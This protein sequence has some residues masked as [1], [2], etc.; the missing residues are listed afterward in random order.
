MALEMFDK[1]RIK[2]F[3]KITG[4][5][6]LYYGGFYEGVRKNKYN[7][8]DVLS[9]L[10]DTFLSKLSDNVTTTDKLLIKYIVWIDNFYGWVCEGYGS[11]S[12]DVTAKIRTFKN[13]YLEY[14][15]KFELDSNNEIIGCIDSLVGEIEKL[16][17]KEDIEEVSKYVA[18]ITALE[19]KISSL[20]ADLSKA[21]TEIGNLRRRLAEEEK[22]GRKSV[23]TNTELRD[24]IQTRDKE[25]REQLALISELRNQI[26]EFGQKADVT[27]EEYEV[28]LQQYKDLEKSNSDLVELYNQLLNENGNLLHIVEEQKEQLDGF[29]RI[30]EEREKELRKDNLARLREKSIDDF[31][32]SLLIG[33]KLSVQEITDLLCKQGYAVTNVDVNNSLK[34]IK[35]EI[36]LITPNVATYPR[37]FSICSPS[38]V[39]NGSFNL[40]VSS[41]VMNVMVISDLH[42]SEVNDDVVRTMDLIYDYCKKMGIDLIMNLGDILSINENITPSKSIFSE[43]N[44]LIESILTRFP[45]D[46]SITHAVLGG[47]HDKGSL[48]L[49]IDLLSKLEDG[50]DDFLNLGYDHCN[51]NIVGSSQNDF[52]GIHHPSRRLLDSIDDY[53]LGARKLINHLDWHYPSEEE[54]KK[55]YIDLFGHFH[56]SRLDMLNQYCSVPSLFKDRETNGAW[57]MK[58]YFDEHNNIKH[59]VFIPLVVNDKITKVSEI[60]YQRVMK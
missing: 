15:S 58:I 60:G 52:F 30:Q 42:L 1:L 40:G 47:N 19:T 43:N 34:R 2:K 31:V 7:D 28:I 13:S 41:K 4:L 11:P 55:A 33:S 46:S 50:R 17:G 22:K 23:A 16:H 56:V 5:E 12:D 49:G 6:D 25:I 20:E 29:V 24:L 8:K 18:S 38:I 32:I 27:K 9:F 37:Q 26:E 21:S 53:K 14:V 35:K 51:V 54:R 57:H 36:N 48:N 44:R 39:T 45:Y 3:L 59:M 10:V